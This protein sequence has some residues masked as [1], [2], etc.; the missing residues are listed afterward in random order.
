MI[1]LA[2][3]GEETAR[4]N[5]GIEPG[6]CAHHNSDIWAKTSPTGGYEWDPRGQSRWACWPMSG[7]WLSTHLWEHYLYTGDQQFLADKAWPLMKG[8]S[9]FGL[10]WLVE[11][12]AGHFVTNPSTSPENV[13][14]IDSVAYQISMATTMDMAILRELFQACILSAEVVGNE[15]VFK[16]EIEAA[17]ERLYP[18]QIGQHGQLQE[19][20]KDWDDPK[21]KHRHLSHLFGLHPGTQISPS[22]TPALAAAARQSLLQRGDAS[23]GWSMA[24]KINWWARLGDGNHAYKIL[25]EGLTYID[26]VNTKEAMSGGGTY[27]NLFDAHPPFQ[28]DGNFGATAGMTEMLL[29]SHAGEINVLPALPDAWKTGSVTGLKTRGGFVVHIGWEEG[30]LRRMR[31]DATL[32]GKCRVSALLP[33]KVIETS[34]EKAMGPNTNP[35]MPTPGTVHFENNS[36]TELP[37]VGLKEV[38]QIDFQTEK[39]KSYTIVPL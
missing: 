12:P 14:K 35:L 18:Y 32:G 9:Q 8:A 11:G 39:G 25:K 20:F 17:L 30:S 23:T 6:W 33:V 13:F 7:A 2:V 5:Y 1:Q 4:I 34:F 31:I 22:T 16:K 21:D 29:Q 19:W 28:I 3:N 27:P 26:P 36:G 37:G 15:D 24:W 38:Y 10:A